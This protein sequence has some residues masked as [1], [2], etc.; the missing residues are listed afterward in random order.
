VLSVALR[1]SSENVSSRME[2][3]ANGWLH[4]LGRCGV[5]TSATEPTGM[6]V[7]NS[8]SA[9]ISQVACKPGLA[10]PL[11]LPNESAPKVHFPSRSLNLSTNPLPSGLSPDP[12]DNYYTDSKPTLLTNCIRRLFGNFAPCWEN[13]VQRDSIFKGNTYCSFPAP[14]G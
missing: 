9:P 7:R 6:R 4:A 8:K 5:S 10:R 14:G 1:C 11:L 3:A 12:N 2:Q 13:C